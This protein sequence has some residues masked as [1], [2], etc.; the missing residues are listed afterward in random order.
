MAS[1]N[2]SISVAEIL[3]TLAFIAASF[4]MVLGWN[5]EGESLPMSV[6]LTLVVDVLLLVLLCGAVKL[7][8]SKPFH[9]TLWRV[10]E[11]MLIVLY[12]CLA[13][14][15]MLPVLSKFVYTEWTGSQTIATALE[16]DHE[17]VNTLF[18]DFKAAC[19][20]KLNTTK[21]GLENLQ[22]AGYAGKH[23][24]ATSEVRNFIKEHLN[25]GGDEHLDKS[26]IRAYYEG[27]TAAIASLR[28]TVRYFSSYDSYKEAAFFERPT[29][30][31]ELQVAYDSVTSQLQT[32]AAQHPYPSI[33]RSAEMYKHPNPSITKS[34][35]MYQY[36]FEAPEVQLEAS[37]FKQALGKAQS[38]NLAGFFIFLLVNF[39]IL[40]PY[41]VAMRPQLIRTLGKSGKD[42]G[43]VPLVLDN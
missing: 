7:K 40:L 32:F 12:V 5:Y 11:W 17:R 42:L 26:N 43:G 10:L 25:G 22:N 24:L 18:N 23:N 20:Q 16:E 37:A 14:V 27:E 9:K 41:I 19:D 30:A 2:K 34:V 36:R 1:N 3:C 33:T 38:F 13:L 31:R 39:F 35:A 21:R 15:A 28:E 8:K 4:L 6:I 29:R